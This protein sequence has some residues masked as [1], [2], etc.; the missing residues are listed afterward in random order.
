MLWW[1]VFVFGGRNPHNT[2]RG[3]PGLRSRTSGLSGNR[4]NY[5]TAMLFQSWPNCIRASTTFIERIWTTRIT[6]HRERL[7]QISTKILKKSQVQILAWEIGLYTKAYKAKASCGWGFLA[8]A[9]DHVKVIRTNTVSFFPAFSR[10]PCSETRPLIK[11]RSQT[12]GQKLCVYFSK[13]WGWASVFRFIKHKRV[14]LGF[15]FPSSI[16]L[17]F[18]TIS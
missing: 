6:M 3:S 11:C 10:G 4:A 7:I 13:R 12:N 17:T 14:D 15:G 16:S 9:A 8:S 5:C 2:Q 1:T 18:F